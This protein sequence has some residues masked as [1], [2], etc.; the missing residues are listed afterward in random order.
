MSAAPT[1]TRPATCLA[2]LV[3]DPNSTYADL[4]ARCPVHEGSVASHFET[5]RSAPNFGGTTGPTY[6]VYRYEA[7]IDVLRRTDLFASQPFYETT[8]TASIGPS[9]ISMDGPEHRRMRSLLQPAFARRR[10]DTWQDTIIR[11]IVD[12]H[13]DRIVALGMPT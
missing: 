8:L 1:P 2:G 10:M 3:D 11:P 5:M 6:G 7:G 12:E 13:L 4:L 9:V